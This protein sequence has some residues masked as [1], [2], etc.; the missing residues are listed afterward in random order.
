[1]PLLTTGAGAYPVSGGGYTLALDGT[2]TFNTSTGSFSV[3]F[4]T[5]LANDI[6]IAWACNQAGPDNPTISDTSGLTWIQQ[7]TKT[8]NITVWTALSTGILSSDT[9]TIGNAG[10][11]VWFCVLAVSGAKTSSYMDGSITFS[12]GQPASITTANANDF[13]LTILNGNG[14]NAA[15]SGWN[16]LHASGSYPPGYTDGEYRIVSSTGTYSNPFG[17]ASGSV[18]ALAIKQGP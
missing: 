11:G 6:L 14:V 5:T 18:A 17:S 13:I 9:V 4:S 1:M 2:P 15:D 8:N 3:S 7:G 16:L 12:T 10:G